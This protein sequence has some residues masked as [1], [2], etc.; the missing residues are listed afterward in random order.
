MKTTDKLQKH[1]CFVIAGW[2]VISWGV[3]C[4]SLLHT[5]PLRVCNTLYVWVYSVSMNGLLPNFRDTKNTSVE[6]CCIFLLETVFKRSLNIICYNTP[7]ETGLRFES[8]LWP[9]NFSQLLGSWIIPPQK[10]KRLFF[11]FVCFSWSLSL[12]LF[13]FSLLLPCV[14]FVFVFCLW[15]FFL[16]QANYAPSV[17]SRIFTNHTQWLLLLI[18]QGISR[19]AQRYML[20]AESETDTTWSSLAGLN[21]HSTS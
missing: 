11:L 20:Q 6:K 15:F 4:K 1:A 13:F 14:F 17:K 16:L 12:S 18:T 2:T 21:L 9:R 5:L 7:W 19:V 3:A 8:E 10:L